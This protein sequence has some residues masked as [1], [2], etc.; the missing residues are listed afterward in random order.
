MTN[1]ADLLARY[2][3]RGEPDDFIE[4]EKAYQTALATGPTP[5][6]LTEYG[7]LLE[8]RATRL[9]RE[10]IGYY[11]RAIELDPDLDKP[12]YQLIWARA[13]LRDGLDQLIERY[14]NPKDVRE[15]RFL[16]QAYLAAGRHADA[17]EVIEAGLNLAPEDPLLLES[18]GQIAAAAGDTEAALREWRHVGDVDPDFLG[19][20]YQSAFLL[21]RAGRRAEAIQTWRE[22]IAALESRESTIDA[23]WPQRE[24]DRLLNAAV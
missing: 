2:E 7:Y 10:A 18:R 9:L 6:L 8:S 20:L 22:L 4:A 24:L 12:H 17:A 1:L 15:H 3:A 14:R 19:P 11:E 23:E 21:E 16:A 13:K 5:R